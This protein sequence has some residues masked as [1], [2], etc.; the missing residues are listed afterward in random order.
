VILIA[1]DG[2][3]D[4]KAAIAEAA[5]LFPGEPA[6]I[7]TVW[8]RFVDTMARTGTALGAPA[9]VD[10]DEVDDASEQAALE[11]AEQGAAFGRERGLDAR[12]GTASLRT[13][14]ADAILLEGERLPARAIVMGTRGLTGIKSMLLGSVSHAVLHDADR[15]VVVVPSPEVAKARA[16]HLAHR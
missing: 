4:A 2:S 15:P 8:Q 11:T 16:E 5:S 7:L 1:Y 12:P 9:I 14:V 13:T 6:T 10:L 3:D